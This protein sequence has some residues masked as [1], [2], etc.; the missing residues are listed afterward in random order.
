MPRLAADKIQV[1]SVIHKSTHARL[2]ADAKKQARSV[3][4]QVRYIL[5]QHYPDP[6]EQERRDE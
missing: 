6:D 2:V 5:E 4:A 1:T 3:S